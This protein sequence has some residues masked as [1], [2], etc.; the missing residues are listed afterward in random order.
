MRLA[1]TVTD[2]VVGGAGLEGSWE[3]CYQTTEWACKKTVGCMSLEFR[4]EV[5]LEINLGVF[6]V[7]MDELTKKVNVDGKQKKEEV[8][9]QSYPGRADLSSEK[10]WTVGRDGTKSKKVP[11][12]EKVSTEEGETHGVKCCC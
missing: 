11:C 5:N 7:R 9:G 3:G 4:D 12:L 8:H 2:K 10:L 1:L 6:C